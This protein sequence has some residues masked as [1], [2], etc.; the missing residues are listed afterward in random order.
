MA[1]KSSA[2]AEKASRAAITNKQK[3]RHQPARRGPHESEKAGSRAS[4]GTISG[5]NVATVLPGNVASQPGPTAHLTP[6]QERFVFEYLKDFNGTQA[7]LRASPGTTESA[8][9]VAASRLLRNAQI[10]AA[11]A[12]QRARLVEKMELTSER[13]LREVARVAFFDPRKLLD[14]NGNP[15]PLNRLDDDTAAVIA[16][17]EVQ[18]ILLGQGQNA[19]PAVIKKY[20][21]SDKMGALDMA[22]RHVGEY[23]KHN[24]QGADPLRTLLDGMQRSTLP[25]VATPP[26]DEL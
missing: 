11:V 25:I 18:Q 9:A 15:L 19:I 22:M 14:E 21:L 17:L 24:K 1:H 20:K 3:H 6:L 4:L 8:A 5:G 2:P 16:G 23:E 12:G 10:A 26:A 7:Y 13:A